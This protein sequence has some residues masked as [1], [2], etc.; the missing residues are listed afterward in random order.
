MARV[1]STYIIIIII[2]IIIITMA[3]N[4]RLKSLTLFFP[5]MSN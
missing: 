5:L 4:R 3:I 1:I 2:I